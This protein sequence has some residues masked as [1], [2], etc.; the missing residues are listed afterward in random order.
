MFK[1]GVGGALDP[2]GAPQGTDQAPDEGGFPASQLAAQV[3]DQAVAGAGG[4][5][6]AEAQGGRLVG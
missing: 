1:Q 3:K 4:E 5:R 2:L 6:G